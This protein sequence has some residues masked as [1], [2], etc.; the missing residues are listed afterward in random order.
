MTQGAE[1]I[2]LSIN[3]FSMLQNLVAAAGFSAC[4]H[5]ASLVKSARV[6][7]MGAAKVRALRNKWMNINYIRLRD[8]R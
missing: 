2:I 3:Q 7:G 1:L 6:Q 5:A 8:L 4:M